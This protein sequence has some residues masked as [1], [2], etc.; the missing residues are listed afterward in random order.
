MNC[1]DMMQMSELRDV[2]CLK[3]GEAGLERSIRWIYFADCLQCVQSEYRMEDYIHGGEFVVLTN[4]SVTDD[5]EK[6]MDL[7]GRMNDHGIAA[8]GINEG[9]ISPML[10]KYCSRYRLPLFELP[11]RFPLVDLSQIVCKRLVLE[12]NNKNLEEQV[13]ASILD[14]EHLN[15]ESV[16]AQARYL[17][18]DLEGNFCVVEFTFDSENDDDGDSLTAG[19]DIKH[20]I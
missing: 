1:K 9:Q 10:E 19:Q 16:L 15:R 12:E 17:K 11:E 18:I 4:R 3:A 8:L 20:V 7:I 14:A 5:R 2:L 13:F 6:L